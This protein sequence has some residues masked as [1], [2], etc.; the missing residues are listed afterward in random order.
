MSQQTWAASEEGKNDYP[1]PWE[2]FSTW[3]DDLGSG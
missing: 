1:W 3:A 2:S